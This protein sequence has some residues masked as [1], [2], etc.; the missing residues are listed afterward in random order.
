MKIINFLKELFKT[1]IIGTVAVVLLITIVPT[2][3]SVFE[4]YF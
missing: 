4:T 1:I 2:L 3:I